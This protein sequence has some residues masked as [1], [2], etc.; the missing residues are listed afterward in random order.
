MAADSAVF[1]GAMNQAG[2]FQAEDF[3]QMMR[4]ASALSL[5][6]HKAKQGTSRIAIVTFSG[7]AGI[8][9]SDLLDRHHMAVADFSDETQKRIQKV[10][11]DWMPASNP[12]D[13]WP[14][15]ERSGVDK[16]YGDTMRAVCADPNV[17]AILLHTF[18]GGLVWQLKL[19]P[20][21]ETAQK[22]GKP[23]FIWMIGKEDE[24]VAFNETAKQLGVPVFRELS[25]AVECM[26]A[27][28]TK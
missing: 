6:G 14:A 26:A 28:L 16:A 21:V 17:D 8:V 18:V 9:S 20:I 13:L 5:Y 19:A 7:G 27:V 10:F 1:K 11:P 2:V 25:R 24:S 4:M 22:A 3:R 23:L 12:V 15:I